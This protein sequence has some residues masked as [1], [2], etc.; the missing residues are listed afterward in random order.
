MRDKGEHEQSPTI[1]C[2]GH[3]PNDP[4][5]SY[6]LPTPKDFN[7]SK[8]CQAFNYELLGDTQVITP[9]FILVHNDS[10]QEFDLFLEIWSILSAN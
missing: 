9:E 8:Q 6:Y 10:V 4:R 1:P 2:K 3:I 7:A 5:T